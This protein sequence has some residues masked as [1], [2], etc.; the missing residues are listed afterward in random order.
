MIL[1]DG[2]F[3]VTRSL[4]KYIEA[5]ATTRF[6]NCYIGIDEH[7]DPDLPQ[8]TGQNN[9]DSMPDELDQVAVG[10][11]I[12]ELIQEATIN[13]ENITE[14]H[15]QT[16]SMLGEEYQQTI[17]IDNKKPKG[18]KPFQ[19]KGRLPQH[20]ISRFKRSNQNDSH[21]FSF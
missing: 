16:L 9:I 14:S 12:D 21:H 3:I 4:A 17:T 19:L 13:D 15:Q 11:D 18:K 7:L 8:N 1:F 10:Q 6:F 20:G 5:G 2:H